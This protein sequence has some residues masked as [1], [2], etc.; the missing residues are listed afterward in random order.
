MIVIANTVFTQSFPG[1]SGSGLLGNAGA[2]NSNNNNGK[3]SGTTASSS[4]HSTDVLTPVCSSLTGQDFPSSA[5]S[6]GAILF[7]CNP[8]GAIKVLAVGTS[9]PKI[10]PSS[11]TGGPPSPYVTLSL[12]LHKDPP[13]LKCVP[14]DRLIVSRTP[15]TFTADDVGHSFDYCASYAITLDTTFPNF[16]VTWSS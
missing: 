10:T 8:Y 4:S 14:S 11:P 12:N 7:S 3:G 16:Q 13:L 5:P 1:H 15:V 9:T 2:N 6:A